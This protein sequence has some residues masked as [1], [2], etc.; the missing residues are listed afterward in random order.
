MAPSWLM[1]GYFFGLLP[2]ALDEDLQ[3]GLGA[4]GAEGGAVA[5]GVGLHLAGHGQHLAHAEA[6][7]DEPG[8]LRRDACLLP[9]GFLHL[10]RAGV[11]AAR[12]E[13]R[14]S[15]AQLAEGGDDVAR[16]A[17]RQRILLRADQDEVVVHHVAAVHAVAVG[18]ELVL[19]RPSMHQHHIDVAVLAQF[20][21]LA[22]ADRNHV[23]LDAVLCL[24]GRQD[25][26]EQP[27][28]LRA[29]CGGQADVARQRRLHRRDQGAEQ[30]AAPKGRA[31]HGVVSF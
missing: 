29:G 24:E 22:G 23:Y 15:L 2:V 28:V 31:S 20:E 18:D 30:Q 4:I 5:Q 14:L 3:A 21:R 27:G 10:V 7:R 9:I 17:Q 6:G 26:L 25:R 13:F 16:A 11:V 8:A 12:D 1:S 19:G